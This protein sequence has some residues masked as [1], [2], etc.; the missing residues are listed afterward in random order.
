MEYAAL[1]VAPLNASE[2][3]SLAKNNKEWVGLKFKSG[4]VL[5]YFCEFNIYFVD[6]TTLEGLSQN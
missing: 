5:T 1:L 4:P 3:W 6:K 2:S